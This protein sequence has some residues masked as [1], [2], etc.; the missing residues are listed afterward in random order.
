MWTT[1]KQIGSQKASGPYG[2]TALFYKQ[3]WP[4]VKKE[5]MDMVQNV[6]K[7]GFI[8]NELNHT[9]IALIPNVE[10]PDMVS[11]TNLAYFTM[12]FLSQDYLEDSF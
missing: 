7:T 8:L 4:I 2:L 10:N 6:F 11:F 1:I 12:Q 3:F 5:V 9:N